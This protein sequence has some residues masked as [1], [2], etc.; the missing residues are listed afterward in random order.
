M[1]ITAAQCRAARAMLDW[2]RDDLAAAARVAKRTVVD[3]ERGARSPIHSTLD[4]LRRA[5]EAAGI[6]FLDGDGVRLKVRP[7]PNAREGAAGG[8]PL[9]GR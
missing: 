6:E 8:G 2:S 4:V 3:F 5:L 1:T 7:E 9:A